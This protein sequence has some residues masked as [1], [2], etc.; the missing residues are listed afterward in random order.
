MGRRKTG[1]LVNGV[2]LLDK[3]IGMSSNAALQQVRRFFDARKAGHTGALDP[4]ATGLLPVCL[5]EATKFSHFLL[6]ADKTYEV[7]AQLGVRT[8]TSDADGEVV[9][10]STVTQTAADVSAL[11]PAFVG[12]QMQQPSLYSALKYEGRPLYYYARNG[13]EVPR[14]QRQI[15]IYSIEL[16]DFNPQLAQAT[17]RVRCSK[18]TY[19]RTLVDDIGERLGCGAHVAQL[20]R[21][22]VSGIEGNMITLD[23]LAELAQQ[24]PTV[25]EL[26][27]LLLPMDATIATLPEVLIDAAAALLFQHGHAVTPTTPVNTS[28][29]VVRVRDELGQF[30]GIAT[31]EGELLQPKRVVNLDCKPSV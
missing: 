8:T 26:D 21:T 4:L 5:G 11:I 29:S 17:M 9:S 28:N 24:A 23:A 13:I 30:H 25:A 27:Q 14:K 18:G 3:P 15:N 16:L 6:D 31:W 2:L 19:I 22:E 7:V 1:R 10:T 12:E 20:R